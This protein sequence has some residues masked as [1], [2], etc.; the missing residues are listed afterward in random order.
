MKCFIIVA[1]LLCTPQPGA[2]MPHDICRELDR[3]IAEQTAWF[4]KE[5]VEQDAKD[6]VRAAEYA[7]FKVR[8]RKLAK[9]EITPTERAVYDKVRA[10][11]KARD[12][13]EGWDR[14]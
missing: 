4:A 12:E 3:K 10:I 6:A 9:A 13:V 5:K 8:M 2:P 11:L 1:A 14:R 7:S